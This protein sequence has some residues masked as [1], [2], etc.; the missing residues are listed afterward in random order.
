MAIQL[1]PAAEARIEDIKK[2]YPGQRSAVMPALYVA[3]EELGYTTEEAILWVAEKLSMPPVHVR[4]VATFYTMYYKKPVGTYHF[5]LCRTLSCALCGSAKLAEQLKN[6]LGV[7]AHEVSA[8]GLFS[9]EEVE[10]LG[11]CGTA[12]LC[13]VNDTFF[14]NLTEE[15]LD[16]LIARIKEERPDLRYSTIRDALGGGLKGCP[17]SQIAGDECS[18]C[19][20]NSR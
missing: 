20:K 10:C 19:T 3:Q 4:E 14:E 13:Q 17:P 2:K 9:F 6:R 15:K 5:Q 7:K 16:T 18:S 12:P 1:S 8:D 11:S